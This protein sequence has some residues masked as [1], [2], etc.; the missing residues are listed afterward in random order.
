[1]NLQSGV[2]TTRGFWHYALTGWKYWLPHSNRP[3]VACAEML[4]GEAVD[5]ACINEISEKSFSTGFRS[6]PTMLAAA[7]NM[8]HL[9]FFSTDL[10]FRKWRDEG[11]AILSRHRSSSASSHPLHKELFGCSLDEAIISVQGKPVTILTA[12]LAL[13]KKHRDIQIREIIGLVKGRTGPLIL[14]GDMN[15]PDP[16]AFDEL[17]RETPLK[18]LCT[19]PT[20]P[21]WKPTKSLDYV[22]LS[23]EFKVQDRYVPKSRAF[24]DHTPL[25]VKAGLA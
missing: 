18:Q 25:I 13:T 6:Q 17:C 2:G 9:H 12:H 11:D 10:P 22:F 3:L 15:E 23:E 5:I 21:S 14:A 4:K 1:M 8:E 19:L 16:K 20:F 7:V 24:S